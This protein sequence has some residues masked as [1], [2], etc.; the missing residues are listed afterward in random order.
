M[1]ILMVSLGIVG[2]VMGVMGDIIKKNCDF[3]LPPNM[4]FFPCGLKTD[5]FW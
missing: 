3:G 5:Y 1:L 2:W 4:M